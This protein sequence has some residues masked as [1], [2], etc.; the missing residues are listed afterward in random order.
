MGRGF[1]SPEREHGLYRRIHFQR[2]PKPDRRGGAPSCYLVS[3]P[4]KETG[5]NFR[6][7]KKS[8]APR[9]HHRVLLC[10]ASNFQQFGIKYTTVGKAGFITACYI[11]IVPVIGLF[12]GKKCSSFIWA[13]VVL[14]LAGLY[15]LCIKDGFSVGKGDFLVLICAVFFSLH[16]LVIDHFSPL[17]DGVKMSCIQFAVCGVLSGSFW[18]IPGSP[19]CLRPGFLFSMRASCP[20][21]SPTLCRSS[22]RRE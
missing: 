19:V 22:A 1:R 13:A 9:P 5:G 8:A 2:R 17:T 18:R 3:E 11:V 21:A 12:L 16:I 15:L 6:R 4:R 14:T 10:L 7:A 20:A